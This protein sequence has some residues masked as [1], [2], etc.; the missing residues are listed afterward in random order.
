MRNFFSIAQPY[1][2]IPIDNYLHDK[3][4]LNFRQT[5]LPI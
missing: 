2:D 5:S 4:I 1:I 3:D